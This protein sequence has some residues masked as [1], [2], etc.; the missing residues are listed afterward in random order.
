LDSAHGAPSGATTVPNGD[1][2]S[3]DIIPEIGITGTPVIDPATGTIYLVGK[4][5]EGPTTYVQRLHALD[6]T[7]GAEKF[8]GPVTISA[9]LPGTGTGSSGGVLNFDPKWELN[10]P[11]LL[12]QHGVIYIAFGSHGDNGPW[13]GWVLS[14]NAS[15]LAKLS[16]YCTT[17]NGGAS[18]IWMS[19][20]GL[21][22]DIVDPTN[23]PFGRLFVATGNG[24]FDATPPYTN[25]MSY[26]DD[27]VRL[28]LS[29][30]ILTVQDSFTP[31]NQATLSINDADLASG[32]I[33]LL[34]N[35]TVGGHT[36]LMVQAG[37]EGKIYL[38]STST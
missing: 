28:D 12:L 17:P 35:Q 3:S 6:I 32:G 14:Y 23:K 4:T 31:F 7:S 8:G 5:K 15:N 27:L 16:A 36:H 25:S 18:G 26:G 30:G 9:S 1:I 2:S 37:K 22:G 34:P 21:A 38:F 33:L 19:G 11:G 10:R 20:A 29:G 24:S 13:H